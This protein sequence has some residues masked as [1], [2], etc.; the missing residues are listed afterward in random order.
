MGIK[1]CQRRARE[2]DDGLII[3]VDGQG[4]S[5]SKSEKLL[6]C[7]ID[8]YMSWTLHMCQDSKSIKA[9][10]MWKLGELRKLASGLKFNNRLIL[11]NGLIM[12]NLLYA[13][14]VWGGGGAG[15]ISKLQRV[16]NQAARWVLGP[17]KGKL[18]KVY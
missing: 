6:G 3:K 12:S 17:M 16:Q 11:A 15:A 1:T 18:A 2:G 14:P 7:T 9:K 13:S 5:P 8:R 10:A 4:K